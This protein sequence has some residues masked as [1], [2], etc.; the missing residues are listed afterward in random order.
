MSTSEPK[1]ST[2]QTG[3]RACPARLVFLGSVAVTLLFF[4][5]LAAAYSCFHWDRWEFERNVRIGMTKTEVERVAGVPRLVLSAGETVPKWGATEP[6]VAT[7][8]TWVYHRE[9]VHRFV[10]TFRDGVLVSIDY[11]L[12]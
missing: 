6:R 4:M 1:P 11:D 9:P 10:L 2:A 8:E 7:Q 3:S 12:T 5:A